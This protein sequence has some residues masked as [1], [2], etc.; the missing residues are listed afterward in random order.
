M[1]QHNR[2]ANRHD[3][4]HSTL[5]VQTR[6]GRH[7][8]RAIGPTRQRRPRDHARGHH[9]TLQ[10]GERRGMGGLMGDPHVPG[11][12]GRSNS[13]GGLG[14]VS[15]PLRASTRTG[16]TA[17]GSERNRS[18]AVTRPLRRRRGPHVPPGRRRRS[19]TVVP[20]TRIRTVICVHGTMPPAVG[21]IPRAVGGGSRTETRNPG[22]RG[23]GHPP[24]SPRDQKSKSPGVVGVCSSEGSGATSA[25]F[26]IWTRLRAPEGH[27]SD[28][29][30]Y[31]GRY[32]PK[33]M[34]DPRVRGG[35]SMIRR[36]LGDA[37]GS[38]EYVQW[39]GDLFPWWVPVALLL[40]VAVALGVTGYV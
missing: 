28:P 1:S 10:K 8:T 18:A 9:Y 23:P 21:R 27:R 17:L 14:A 39:L 16:P 40:I 25:R 33:Y 2:H 32:A 30:P 6:T 29:T 34:T 15:G 7:T 3:D 20:R 4:R 5:R 11:A 38:D 35:G 13:H 19:P 26:L 36:L 37:E 31:S 24:S 22:A 12:R